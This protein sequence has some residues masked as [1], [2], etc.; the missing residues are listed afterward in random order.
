MIFWRKQ[1]M[2]LKICKQD[3]LGLDWK[4]S[5][6]SVEINY[7]QDLFWRDKLIHLSGV[8][9]FKST[10]WYCCVIYC[11]AWPNHVSS[12]VIFLF[13][14]IMLFYLK[15][16]L[17]TL[18]SLSYWVYIGNLNHVRHLHM[19]T[20]LVYQLYCAQAFGSLAIKASKSYWQLNITKTIATWYTIT[21]DIFLDYLYN[22]SFIVNFNFFYELHM[23]Y[24][25]VVLH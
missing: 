19:K 13:Y 20:N 11:N 1:M 4:P 18:Y 23:L 12:F 10:F 15:L 6:E 21:W 25:I 8:H 24:Y 22:V 16:W 17:Y 3:V 9:I 7:W 5:F 14:F 2:I